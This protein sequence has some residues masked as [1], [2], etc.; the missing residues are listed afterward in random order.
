MKVRNKTK[1]YTGTSTNFNTHGLG[2]MIVYFDD[3]SCDS[4]YIHDYEA[5]IESLGDWVD[6]CE[7]F[8]KN[9]II[10]DNYNTW[11]REPLNLEEEK[12]GYFD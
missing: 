11:F 6:M 7:A 12:Q 2:E 8:N 3:D 9:L 4:E 10:P 1:G 5:L